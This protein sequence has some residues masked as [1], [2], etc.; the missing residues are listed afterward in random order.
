MASMAAIGALRLPS[1]SS[2]S[3]SSSSNMSRKVP[4]T[5]MSFLASTF[6]GE[7]ISSKAFSV[8]RRSTERTP[9][10]VCPKAV[11]DSKNSQ[12]CLDPDAS[13]VSIFSNKVTVS[14]VLFL[15]D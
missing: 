10:I 2:S 11:S 8:N 15:L 7:K 1:S 13:R 3:S 4:A 14:V 6:T 12:T 5:S 9:L